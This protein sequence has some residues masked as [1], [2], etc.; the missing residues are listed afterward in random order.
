MLEQRRKELVREVKSMV[1]DGYMD[2]AHLDSTLD[3]INEMSAHEVHST[4]R[5]WFA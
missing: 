4:W 1:A 3:A 5:C 2:A